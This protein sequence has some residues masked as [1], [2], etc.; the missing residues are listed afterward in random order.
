MLSYATQLGSVRRLLADLTLPVLSL[1]SGSAFDDAVKRVFAR[2]AQVRGGAAGGAGPPWLL[3]V[4]GIGY[5][6]WSLA[7]LEH[8]AS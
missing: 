6:V 4:V 5:S 3:W 2:G 7:F 1:F 8:S